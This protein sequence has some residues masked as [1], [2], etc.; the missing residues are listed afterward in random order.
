MK[1]F[2][3]LYFATPEANKAMAAATPKQ[4]AKGMESWMK[5]AQKC[6][7]QLVEMGAPLGNGQSIS[8]DGT[9]KKSR[10]NVSGYSIIQA[11]TLDKARKLLKGHPHLKAHAECSIDLNEVIPMPEM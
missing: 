6:G 7:D 8:I 4:Q 10:K 5:W 11:E 2:V 3:V 9:A 1:K